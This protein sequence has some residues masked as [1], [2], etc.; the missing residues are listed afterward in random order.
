MSEQAVAEEIEVTDTI[1][2][3][4]VA[5]DIPEPILEVTPREKEESK[6]CPTFTTT[7]PGLPQK[8][9]PKVQNNSEDI[10]EVDAEQ[11]VK[12][13]HKYPGTSNSLVNKIFSV[14]RQA[15]ESNPQPAPEYGLQM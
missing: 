3:T 1:E 7:P 15:K 2:V 11:A 10:T 4:E 12:K 6:N 9:N 14:F 13:T 8:E 5:A